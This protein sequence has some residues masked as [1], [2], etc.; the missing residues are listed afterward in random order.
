M[1]RKTTMA[2]ALAAIAHFGYWT[3]GASAQNA[4]PAKDPATCPMH[5]ELAPEGQDE[6]VHHDGV[7]TRGD[8]EMGFSHVKTTH[9]FHLT[10]D[11]GSIEVIANDASDAE[12]RDRIRTHLRSIAKEFSEGHFEAPMAIHH[13]IPPGV[14]AM[15]RRKADITYTYE[16]TDRGAIVHI[17]T[18]SPDALDAVHDFLRFQIQDHQTGDSLEVSNDRRRENHGAAR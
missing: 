13:R 14:P 15:E 11:G 7:N 2:V 9:H 18:K 1:T 16:Q 6:K 4:A 8:S 3:A 5:A 12:S 17:S 10:P